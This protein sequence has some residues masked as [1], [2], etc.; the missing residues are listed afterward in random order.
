MSI[1]DYKNTL[2]TNLNFVAILFKYFWRSPDPKTILS[3]EPTVIHNFWY[4]LPEDV[5]TIDAAFEH[6]T[7][8]RI[9]FF[10]G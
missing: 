4:N 1:I 8:R 7:N 10:Y 6:P 2:T 3:S 5:E 9:Y